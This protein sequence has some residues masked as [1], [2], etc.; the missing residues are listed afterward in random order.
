MLL[1]LFSAA[2]EGVAA[3]GIASFFS[4]SS[5][6]CSF[7]GCQLP[8]LGHAPALPRS[9]TVLPDFHAPRRHVCHWKA[10]HS[11]L[12]C[13]RLHT[14]RRRRR[15]DKIDDY[16]SPAW[17]A[18]RLHHT[19]WRHKLAYAAPA[20]PPL[21]RVY[22]VFMPPRSVWLSPATQTLVDHISEFCGLPAVATA[23]MAIIRRLMLPGM[24]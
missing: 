15:R 4:P 10:C 12:A 8:L 5:R 16:F 13:C 2:Q 20:P 24:G 3:I 11:L 18:A 1:P 7:H 21:R 19:A 14:P 9:S 6:G 17:G 23:T 22:A